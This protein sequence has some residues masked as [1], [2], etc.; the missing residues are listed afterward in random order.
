MVNRL[1]EGGL[2]GDSNQRKGAVLA[3]ITALKQICDHPAAYLRDDD[4]QKVLAGRSGKLARLEEIV[5][6]VFSAGER[7][8]IFTHFARWGEVLARHL[9]EQTGQKI[10]CYHG[11]LSRSVRDQLIA[12][13][14]AGSGAGALVLSIKRRRIRSQL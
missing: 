13:F 10:G 7:I 8:L 1:I 11:G 14:Q 12:Q 3:A 9:S 2:D 6:D 5:A 4:D